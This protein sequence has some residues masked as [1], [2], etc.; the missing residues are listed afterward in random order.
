MLASSTFGHEHVVGVGES[1]CVD[2]RPHPIAHTRTA[3]IVAWVLFQGRKNWA[4]QSLVA[5]Y[6][7]RC[8]K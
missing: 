6:F 7:P 1:A 3:C 2:T 5:P 4:A 8:N